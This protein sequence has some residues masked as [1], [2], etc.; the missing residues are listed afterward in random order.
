MDL[1]M[2]E[3]TTKLIK[4]IINEFKEY[5]DNLYEK[6]T[7][8]LINY[9]YLD[10]SCEVNEDNIDEKLEKA[11][12]IFEFAGYENYKLLVK[13]N[14]LL[15]EKDK[16]ADINKLDKEMKVIQEKKYITVNEFEKIYNISKSSQKNLRNRL[17]DKLPYHQK[18]VGGKIVYVVNEVEKWFENQYK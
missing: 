4:S 9:G 7:D 11:S 13:L 12:D 8:Y 1:T 3:K 2:N 17:T 14:S 15:D 18:V 10:V 5:N 6:T 16:D